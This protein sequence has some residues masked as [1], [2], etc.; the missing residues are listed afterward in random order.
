MQIQG[1]LKELKKEFHLKDSHISIISSL[2]TRDLIADEICAATKIP[3]GKIYELLNELMHVGL[4]KKIKQIPALYSAKNI[5]SNTMDF[6]K[7][8]FDDLMAKELR[9]MSLLD[10]EEQKIE[11][12]MDRKKCIFKLMRSL[13]KDDNFRIVFGSKAVPFFFY[14]EDDDMHLRI[15]NKLSDD[16]DTLSGHNRDALLHK[17]SYDKAYAEK[18]HFKLLIT[19]EALNLQIE[20]LSKELSKKEFKKVILD[21]KK[22]IQKPNIELRMMK[23]HL[24]N[25]IY[26][27]NKKLFIVMFSSKMAIT[28]IITSQKAV[29]AFANHFDDIYKNSRQINPYLNKLLKR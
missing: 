27:T 28:L 26:L 17:N 29:K 5:E 25:Y 1:I 11:I 6:L 14:P 9:V 13:A 24:F 23:G 7:Y 4:V 8:C 19:E 12:L 3:K 18:K 21:I 10:K 16:R 2:K 15:R 22:H 20:T